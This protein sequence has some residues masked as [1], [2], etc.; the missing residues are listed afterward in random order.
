[1]TIM[2]TIVLFFVVLT[3]TSVTSFPQILTETYNAT[4][5]LSSTASLTCHVM[6]LGDHHV[7][8]FKIDPTTLSLSPLA[9]GTQLFT[10]DRRFSVSFYSTSSEHSYWSLDI[11]QVTLADQGTYTCRI[12]NR[13]ASVSV[14]IDLIVQL[15]MDLRPTTIQIEPGNFL[16]L[17]CS[18][19]LSN[20]TIT[21]SSLLS[22]LKWHY[23][24]ENSNRTLFHD[25]QI[26]KT[27]FEH[28]LISYL[29]IPHV[30]TYHAGVWKCSFENQER[31]TT[32]S[33]QTGKIEL[34]CV[35]SFNL[36]S[37]LLIRSFP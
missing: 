23:V 1:M 3:D 26:R 27:L 35:F 6:D 15:P 37:V 36:I 9:V 10:A 2:I 12:A 25:V 17:N 32:I 29:T 14:E 20:E 8:W 19:F 31:T 11:Y 24:S 13:R 30:R 16:E 4:F 21:R 28:Y 5:N 34:C 22:A 33:V 7:T 18:I